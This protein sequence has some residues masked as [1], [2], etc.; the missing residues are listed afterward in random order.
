M[1]HA[2]YLGFWD[3]VLVLEVLLASARASVRAWSVRVD[4]VPLLPNRACVCGAASAGMQG[5]CHDAKVLP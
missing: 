2:G 4:P 3:G 5:F 1:L